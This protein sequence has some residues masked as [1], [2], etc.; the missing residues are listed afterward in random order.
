MNQIE[1]VI[2]ELYANN[3]SKLHQLCQ[4][5]M[6]KFG[7]IYQKDYDDFYSRAGYEIALAKKNYNPLKGN[8]MEYIAGIIRFS[9]LK[10]MRDRNRRKR[11]IIVE[12]EEGREYL[13]DIFIDMPVEEES[14]GIVGEMIPSG[15]NLEEII[16]EKM[17]GYEDKR[18]EQYLNH[19]PKIQRE[20][21]EMKMESI[22]VSK[23]KEK[24]GLSDKLY[25]EYCKEL[26]SFSNM[27][28]LYKDKE[29]EVKED[30]LGMSTITQTMEN[31]KTDKISISS[32]I[33]KIEKHTI[34][35]DHPLQRE[36]EQWS[37]SMKGNLVSDILQ[38]HKL[39]PLIF[40]EQIINGVPIIWD[41]DGKQRCT[42]AYLFSKNGYKVSKNIR[43]WMIS[44]QIVKKDEKGKDVLDKNGFPMVINVEFDI[45]GKKFSDLPEELQ[46]RFLDYSF[47][48]DQ[49]L[50]CSEEDIGY[51]IERY[52]DGKPMTSPQK[53]ITKLGTE[54]AEMVKAISNMPFFKERGAYK[55]SEFRNGTI[56]RVI[57]ESIMAVHYLDKW[58]KLEEMC[59]YIKEN[60]TIGVFR[61]FE[62]MVGRLEKVITDKSAHV[63]NSKDSFL[64]FALFARFRKIGIED[65]KFV[66]FIIAFTTSLHSKGI[67]GVSFDSIL[68]N[69]KSTKDK[70]IVRKKI[71]HLEKLMKIYLAE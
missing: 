6:K 39:H 16:L 53:G 24:L 70:G 37:P 71:I 27:C 23:I 43:R 40:A 19:L 64:W 51:H 62:K 13:S 50:N 3:E 69:T 58:N 12:M 32:I 2:E 17:E 30:K 28:I 21:L 25:K 18:I 33:K 54:Y 59:K 66:E 4:K 60:A 11:Q 5:E 48:Y 1:A 61:D 68:A 57:V 9:I 20:I 34:R 29:R 49:Y 15:F 36:S 63:F 22:P 47:N 65:K 26:K 46:D 67:D 56:N 41:L 38:G 35:F 10:E 31:C 42:N 45:R 8:G 55:I 7:G 44:Y 14:K 52:N